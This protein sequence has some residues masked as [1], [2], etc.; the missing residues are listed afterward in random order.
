MDGSTFPDEDLVDLQEEGAIDAVTTTCPAVDVE[1]AMFFDGTG[2]NLANVEEGNRVRANGGATS[3]PSYENDLSNVAKLYQSYA[4][5]VP[6]V[7]R[8]DCGGIGKRRFAEIIDGIGTTSGQ[9]DSVLGFAVGWGITGVEERVKEGFLRFLQRLNEAKAAGEIKSIKLDVFGFSR[10]SAAARHFVNC[11]R[12]GNAGHGYGGPYY[13]LQE[14]DKPKLEIRFLGLFDTVVS[15]GLI[16]NDS[17]WGRLKITLPDDIATKIVH[18]TALDEH[19]ENFPLTEAP[20][21]AET[22]RMPGAHSD[23]GGGYADFFVE[24]VEVE[25]PRSDFDNFNPRPS[26]THEVHGF[27]AFTAED[28]AIFNRLVAQGWIRPTDRSALTREY[29]PVSNNPY[30]PYWNRWFLTRDWL[31]NPRLAHVS[32]HVMFEKAVEAGVPFVSLLPGENYD[33]PESDL[34]LAQL[35][36]DLMAGRVFTPAETIPYRRDYVHHSAN[37]APSGPVFP[38]QPHEGASR[39]TV[40]GNDGS[41]QAD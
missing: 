27:D 26:E 21:S 16:A 23:I 31:R 17:N 24:R 11:V 28:M 6:S 9:E 30:D 13:E 40:Y 4:R 7:V 33:L 22:I 20:A 3:E 38:M 35:K 12:R 41:L 32:L 34:V 1:I 19:R 18:I 25:R 10:G 37:W 29:T 14:E 15:W 39:R 5:L 8:N 36:A 2:N